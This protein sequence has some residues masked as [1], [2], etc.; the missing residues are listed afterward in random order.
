M[1][2]I[3]FQHVLLMV[4]AILLMATT[5][6]S[7]D[8][9]SKKRACRHWSRSYTHHFPNTNWAFEEEVLEFPFDIEDTTQFYEVSLSLLFDSSVVTLTDIPL[10]LTLNT[11]DGMQSMSKSHFLLDPRTNSDIKLAEDGKNM[12]ATVVVFPRRKLKAEGAYKLVVYRRA[13]KADNFGFTSLT[14]TVKVV[15]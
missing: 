3:N 5:M 11:P 2:R 13:E 10:S 7:C 6:T 1:K 8:S 15:K 4:V 12:E 9:I 14:S